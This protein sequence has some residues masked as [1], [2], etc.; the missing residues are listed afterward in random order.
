MTRTHDL[1]ITKV[2][3]AVQPLIFKAFRHFSLRNQQ[4]VRAVCSVVSA[5]I[6]PVVGQK[7][8]QI[9]FFPTELDMNASTQEYPHSMCS[10]QQ[11]HQ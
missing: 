3:K 11:G 10:K 6:F 5:E 4:V 7:V 2:T 9:S 1:L 8:G